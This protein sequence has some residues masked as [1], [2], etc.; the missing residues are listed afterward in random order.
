MFP[1]SLST[2]KQTHIALSYTFHFH[3]KSDNLPVDISDISELQSWKEHSVR[4]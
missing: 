4:R 2:K 1:F 3:V